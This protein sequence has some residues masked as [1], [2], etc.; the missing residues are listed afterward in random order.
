MKKRLIIFNTLIVAIALILMF[1]LGVY[2]TK[3]NNREQAEATIKNLTKI[4]SGYYLKNPDETPVVVD[5]M[6]LTIIEASGKVTFDN[7]ADVATMDNHI[8]REEVQHAL[9]GKPQV[10]IRRSNTLKKELMY[11][12]EKVDV[13]DS[14]VFIRV[15][16]TI[17]SVDAYVLKSLPLMITIFIVSLWAAAMVSIFISDSL[18][19][20][21]KGI[22]SS[23][24]AINKGSYNPVLRFSG[25]AEINSILGEIDRISEKIMQMV[26]A[27]TQEKERMDFIFNNVSDAII[28]FNFRGDIEL[29]NHNALDLFGVTNAIGKKANILTGD[30]VFVDAIQQCVKE[31]ENSIFEYT[32]GPFIYLTAVRKVENRLTIVVLSDITATK[33]AEKNRSDFFANASHELKTPLTSVKGFN[34]L[35]MLKSKD[36]EIKGFATHIEKESTRMLALIDDMLNLSKLENQKELKPIDV[37]LKEV[38]DEVFGTLSQFASDKN[39]LLSVQGSGTVYAEREHIFEVIK[40]LVEN[41]IRYNNDGGKVDVKISM[42]K[43][44][45]ILEVEDN[46]IGIDESNQ[47]RIFE[48]FYRV[49]KSRSRETAGTGLGLAIVKHAAELYNA[50]VRLQSKIGVGTSVRV[51]FKTTPHPVK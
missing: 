38:T 20:P 8:D 15:S 22:K 16:T 28:V 29:I 51:I 11:Y 34:E 27:S 46:G 35:I 47:T 42:K 37:D 4:Y 33:N 25:D 44:K 10:V 24:E 9:E 26:D 5:D 2:V 7:K 12:A 50:N 49:D 21:F 23:L 13:G 45:T 3:N 43:D 1:V 6:R 18:L 17:K 40:N 39:I 41:G 30:T 31:S 32:H 19:K 48:R 14:Y 36:E